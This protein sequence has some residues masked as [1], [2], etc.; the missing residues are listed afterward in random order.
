MKNGYFA[1]VGRSFWKD[2]VQL[3]VRIRFSKGPRDSN[4]DE[5]QDFGENII[6]S[7]INVLEMK[8]SHHH[9]NTVFGARGD[10]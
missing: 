3:S 1:F 5:R 8:S 6:C 7:F 4:T 10:R 9:N 2:K